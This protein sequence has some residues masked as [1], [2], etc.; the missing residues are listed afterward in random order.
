MPEDKIIELFRARLATSGSEL[1][2]SI[3]IE[4]GIGDDAAVVEMPANRQLVLASDM[5]VETKHF[6]KGISASDIGWRTLIAAASD[7][8]AMAAQPHWCLMSIKLPKQNANLLW[9]NEYLD[10]V[11]QALKATGLVCIGGD[12]VGSDSD[13]FSVDW[14]V[15]GSVEPNQA[16]L[17]SS[18]KVDDVIAVSGVIG[19]A[20]ASIDAWSNGNVDIKGQRLGSD[21]LRP[22]TTIDKALALQPYCN[23]LTDI[24][25]GLLLDLQDILTASGY[26]A[27][28]DLKAIPLS[29][30]WLNSERST[31]DKW[32]LSLTASDDYQLCCTIDSEI[33]QQKIAGSA[34]FSWLTPIGKVTRDTS[35]DLITDLITDTGN[36]LTADD[37]MKRRWHHF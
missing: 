13:N 30:S 25:D 35:I 37:L 4:V 5:A 7:L 34:E 15:A 12:M 24:S 31:L 18:A 14:T 3:N 11:E 2:N 8:A 19:T 17:R 10:G 16:L 27:Q 32:S 9:L 29:S 20:A 22:A 23:A 36:S 1:N 26:G 6:P 21:F 33:W 28:L